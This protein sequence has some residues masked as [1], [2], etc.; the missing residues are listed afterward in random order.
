MRLP[1]PSKPGALAMTDQRMI[2]DLA[3]IDWILVDQILHPQSGRDP[4][5]TVAKAS[6]RIDAKEKTNGLNM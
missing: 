4:Q 6:S 1:T 2:A 3:C 5:M